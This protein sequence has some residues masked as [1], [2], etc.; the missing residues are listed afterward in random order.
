MSNS[1]CYKV[2]YDVDINGTNAFKNGD[3]NHWA[4]GAH[5][6]AVAATLATSSTI[7][8][9]SADPEGKHST[10]WWLYA[11]PGDHTGTA[12]SCKTILLDGV[13]PPTPEPLLMEYKEPVNNPA[14]FASKYTGEIVVAPFR[15]G[16]VLITPSSVPIIE[17]AGPCYL[18]RGGSNLSAGP[19]TP[20]NI[21]GWGDGTYTYSTIQYYTCRHGSITKFKSVYDLISKKDLEGYF[22]YNFPILE[23][24]DFVQGTVASANERDVDILTTIFELP[25]TI[26]SIGKI[27]KGIRKIINN[28]IAKRNVSEKEKQRYLLRC[29]SIENNIR[30]MLTKYSKKMSDATTE[31]ER[32]KWARSLE[33]WQRKLKRFNRDK[34]NA[35]VAFADALASAWLALRYEIM[36]IIYTCQGIAKTAESRWA[37]YRTTRDKMIDADDAPRLEGFTFKGEYKVIWKCMV[38]Y[39]YAQQES[40]SDLRKCFSA[41]AFLTIWELGKLTFVLDW[42]FSVG[43]F[44]SASFGRPSLA[45]QDGMTLSS[46]T[47]LKGTYAHDVSGLSFDID[48]EH[49]KRDVI[50]LQDFSGIFLRINLNWMRYA[51]AGALLFG[52]LKRHFKLK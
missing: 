10:A 46:K 15:V 5:S 12:R 35:L 8:P 22:K 9:A 43:N 21:G 44:L 45:I 18:T 29:A 1:V 14:Y 40:L 30:I 34:R 13:L 6:R 17:D 25:E 50:K 2:L 16:K 52:E 38:K 48:S 23:D 42:F 49:Y 41:N 32:L 31:V 26:L 24:P 47:T 11:A 3:W 33:Y 37:T 28:Y 51:D 20:T 36:P 27:Y 7:V 39:R 19:L 4:P